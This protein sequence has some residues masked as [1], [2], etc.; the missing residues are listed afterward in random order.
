G[1]PSARR[2]IVQEASRFAR[3]LTTLHERRPNDPLLQLAVARMAARRGRAELAEQRPDEA[4]RELEKA[5][6][7][8]SQL[9]ADYPQSDWAVTRPGQLT[10]A[11]GAT[12][13]PQE[14]G[15]ILV[16]GNNPDQDTYTIRL[17]AH[18]SPVTAVRLEAMPDARL[19]ARA[20]GRA[21]N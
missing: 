17:Q 19:P 13:T 1:S 11:G 12:F 2:A 7:L 18:R 5:R 14:D 3:V 15:S 21:E 16:E 4:R 8:F 9:L 6:D 10:S 20:A